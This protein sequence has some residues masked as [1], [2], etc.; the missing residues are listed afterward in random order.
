MLLGCRKSPAADLELIAF[1]L[2]KLSNLAE[3]RFCCCCS[4][5]TRKYEKLE[6]GNKLREFTTCKLWTTKWNTQTPDNVPSVVYSSGPS[7]L[8]FESQSSLVSLPAPIEPVHLASLSQYKQYIERLTHYSSQMQFFF[9]TKS[10]CFPL[11]IPLKPSPFISS[12]PSITS[13][14]LPVSLKSPVHQ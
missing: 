2:N 5:E 9:P 12:R 7:W 4:E 13:L 8:M 1:D 10:N 14:S 11:S 6:F 3:S